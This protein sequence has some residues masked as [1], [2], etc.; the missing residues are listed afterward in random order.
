M[1]ITENCHNCHKPNL[2]NKPR[3]KGAICGWCGTEYIRD[4]EGNL[5][6]REIHNNHKEK[7]DRISYWKIHKERAR[8]EKLRA[9]SA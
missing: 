9:Q 7:K 8:K 3:L 4:R 2:I 6:V 5:V 1:E